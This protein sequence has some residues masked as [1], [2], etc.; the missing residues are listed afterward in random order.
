[1]DLKKPKTAQTGT[2]TFQEKPEMRQIVLDNYKTHTLSQLVELTNIK[3][4]TLAEF[5]RIRGLKA[6]RFAKKRENLQ[7]LLN[8]SGSD[9]AYFGGLIDGEGT[10]TATIS[11]TQN[12]HPY[13]RI[14]LIVTNTSFFLLKYLE[15]LG[16]Y[17]V[18]RINNMGNHYWSIQ[19]SGF[20]LVDF[21]VK[22]EPFLIIKKPVCRVVIELCNERMKQNKN[23]IPT[24]YM[25]KLVQEVRTLN[26]RKDSFNKEKEIYN[27]YMTSLQKKGLSLPTI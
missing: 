11:K 12:G 26:L 7:P 17:G 8:L 25:E 27:K 2:Y 1:M 3:Y 22:L 16:F 20:A 10:I 18:E 24:P 13:L 21:L 15:S 4:K 6:D 19:Q 5:L 14:N 9:L 23:D